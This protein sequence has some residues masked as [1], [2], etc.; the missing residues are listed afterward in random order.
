MKSHEA[1][2]RDKRFIKFMEKL[3]SIKNPHMR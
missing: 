3:A 1:G 2:I